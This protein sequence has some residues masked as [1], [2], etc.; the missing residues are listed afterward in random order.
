MGDALRSFFEAGAK[1]IMDG[2]LIWLVIIGGALLL[3][4]GGY[5]FASWAKARKQSGRL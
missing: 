5:A 1:D 3:S 2:G 4:G